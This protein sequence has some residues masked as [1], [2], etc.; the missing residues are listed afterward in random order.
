MM[1]YPAD[2][3]TGDTGVLLSFLCVKFNTVSNLP[4]ELIFQRMP[5]ATVNELTHKFVINIKDYLR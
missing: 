2:H 4:Q 3:T 1:I 5:S